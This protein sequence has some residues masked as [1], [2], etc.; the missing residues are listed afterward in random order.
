VS[1]GG[2]SCQSAVRVGLSSARFILCGS[3]AQMRL[4]CGICAGSSDRNEQGVL[5]LVRDVHDDW[6]GWPEHMAVTEPPVCL[7][8]AQLSIRVCP[9]LRMGF[10]AIRAGRYRKIP[11]FAGPWRLISSGNS[12]NAPSSS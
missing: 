12:R 3:N 1:C 7:P 5:W 11:R 4:L 2:R 8:C 10:V 6:P 9:S